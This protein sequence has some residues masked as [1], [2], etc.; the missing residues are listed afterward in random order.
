MGSRSVPSTNP[1]PRQPDYQE[2]NARAAAHASKSVLEPELLPLKVAVLQ[3]PVAK[4][5]NQPN[6]R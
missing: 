4:W 1:E 3:V 6:L 5:A 2:E